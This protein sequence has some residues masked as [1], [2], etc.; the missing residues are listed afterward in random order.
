MPARI[1]FVAKP[2]QSK[3]VLDALLASLN[4]VRAAAREAPAGASADPQMRDQIVA[5]ICS[6]DDVRD[7]VGR[8]PQR[9]GATWSRAKRIDCLVLDARLPAVTRRSRSPTTSDGEPRLDSLPVIALR[10]RRG[11]EELDGWRSLAR[12]VVVRDVHSPERLL[13][14]ASLLPA[15]QPGAN[16]RDAPRGA[17]PAARLEPGPGRTRRC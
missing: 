6:A 10:R 9:R 17:A 4:A 12:S 3:D 2:I 5:A 15:S 13:D 14:Q 8:R 7:H 1:A 11:R 16:P